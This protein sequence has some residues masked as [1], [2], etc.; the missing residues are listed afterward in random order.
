[1]RRSTTVLALASALVVLLGAASPGELI[2]HKANELFVAKKFSE[3]AAAVQEALRLDP[4]L[5]P[6]WTLKGKLAMA[7]GQTEIAR[8]SLEQ[9]V[10]LDPQSSY[11]QFMLGFFWYYENNFNKA[12]PHLE[13]AHALNA[14]DADPVLYLAMTQEELGLTDEAMRYYDEAE[15]LE[16]A[17]GKLGAETFLAHAR[18]L[19]MLSRFKESEKR[20]DQSLVIDPNSRNAHWQKGRLLLQRGDA[21]GAVQQGGIALETKGP[22]PIDNQIH[23]LLGRAY[24]A[25]GNTERSKLHFNAAKRR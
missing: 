24:A 17:Q 20:V 23:E 3:S 13:K 14:T 19:F 7:S 2:Y 9:A 6:A 15:S 21:A 12:M 1:M 22:G 18:L 11:A 25:I 4:K 5:V 16:G 10:S 8:A